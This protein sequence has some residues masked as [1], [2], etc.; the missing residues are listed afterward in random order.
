MSAPDISTPPSRGLSRLLRNQGGSKNDSTN[1]LADSS[2]SDDPNAELG[3]GL[4][5]SSSRGVGDRLADRIRRRSVD[6]RRDSAD[7]TKQRLSSLLPSRRNKLKRAKSSELIAE[8]APST[9]N[10]DLTGNQSDHEG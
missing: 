3:V 1:S 4:R 6:D 5:P 9:E 2:N 10:L 8:P 7:S